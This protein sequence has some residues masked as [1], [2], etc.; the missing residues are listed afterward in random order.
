[1]KVKYLGKKK[2]MPV[3]LP[4]GATS[5]GTIKK[6]EFAAPFIELSD[7][8][9]LAL[10]RLDPHNFGLAEVDQKELATDSVMEV[11]A[12]PKKRGRK[13]K[14]RVEVTELEESE[15]TVIGE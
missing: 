15:I 7:T 6:V 2:A 8:D 1:M 10:V 4:I 5:L 11:P 9:A 14:P 13:P 3:Y 12:E